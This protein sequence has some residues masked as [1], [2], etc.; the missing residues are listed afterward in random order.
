MHVPAPPEDSHTGHVVPKYHKLVFPL[1]DGKDDPLGW[2]NKCEQFLNSHQTRHADRVWLASYHLTG[3]AQQWYLVLESDA[4]RPQWEEFRTL[5]QQRFG[6]PL[7]TNHLSNLACLPFTSTVDAYMEAFEARAAHAGRLSSGQKA[8]LF[9]GGLPD[10]IR[11]DV[12]L[13]DPQDL[14]RAMHL[15]RAYERRNAPAPLALPAPPRRRSTKVP[16]TFPASASS[17]ST[18]PAPAAAVQRPFK[19]LSPEEMADRRKQG[20]CYNCDEPYVRGHKC[21]RLFY[22]E[23][24]DYIVKE[25]DDAD[26]D[27]AAPLGTDQPPFD[28]DAPLISLSAITGIC[29]SDTM[30][31]CV[32]IGAHELI[33]LLD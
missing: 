4:G 12:E 10:H 31:L 33:A 5:C 15:A 32:Q 18:P 29:A 28:P 7:S 14:Q 22:L 2:L 6:P 23:V 19:R 11:V 26:D 24:N 9:T 16:N 1:F 8:K 20:L 17:S 27:K 25:P 30:Q 21:A 3:V 13:H